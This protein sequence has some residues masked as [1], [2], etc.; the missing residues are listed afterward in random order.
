MKFNSKTKTSVGTEEDK[1]VTTEEDKSSSF[2][3][4][5]GREGTGFSSTSETPG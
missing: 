5:A 4:T 3:C 2:Q 1:S